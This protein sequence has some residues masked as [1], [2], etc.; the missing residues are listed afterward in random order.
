MS[1]RSD[2]AP[3]ISLRRALGFPFT[4][5]NW[6]LTLLYLGLLQYVPLVGWI[7]LRGWRFD[8]A[9][10]IG[11][12]CDERLP[13]WRGLR[14]HWRWG[15]ILVTASMV[16][17]LPLW[18]AAWTQRRVVFWTL[19]AIGQWWWTR[20]TDSPTEPFPMEEFGPGLRALAALLAL[21]LLYPPLI[22]AVL[23]TGTHRYADTGRW[24]ALYEFWKNVWGAGEDFWDVLRIEG[25]ILGLN[26]LVG[27]VSLILVYTIGGAFLIPPLMFPVY[28]WTRGALMGQWIRKNRWEAGRSLA[29]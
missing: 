16:H 13:D 8:L 19:V 4:R 27:V 28:M 29:S 15:W 10:R 14:E 18:I 2:T 1:S 12:E 9:R 25:G 11:A 6:P 26:V 21:F 17:Y 22:N 24:V 23:E 20:L 5:R 3:E 7:V